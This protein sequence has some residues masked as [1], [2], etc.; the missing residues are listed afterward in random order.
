M[1][2]RIAAHLGLFEDVLASDGRTNLT[3]HEKLAL[4]ES[5][6]SAE[7]FDYIGNAIPDLPLL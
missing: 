6:F 1:A 4:M 2:R 7:G 3:G 5:R